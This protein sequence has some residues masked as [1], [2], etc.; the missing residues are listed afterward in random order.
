M[1]LRA[2]DPRVGHDPYDPADLHPSD[3]FRD[4]ELGRLA[5]PPVSGSA[6]SRPR[7]QP[8]RR[9]DF[10]G[11]RPVPT[12]AGRPCRHG[13]RDRRVRR[14]TPTRSRGRQER[15]RAVAG[16]GSGCDTGVPSDERKPCTPPPADPQDGQVTGSFPLSAAG[17][18]LRGSARRPFRPSPA[19]TVSTEVRVIAKTGSDPDRTQAQATGSE[20]RQGRFPAAAAASSFAHAGSRGPGS[21]SPSSS[22]TSRSVSQSGPGSTWSSGSRGSGLMPASRRRTESATVRRRG[23][24]ERGHRCPGPPANSALRGPSP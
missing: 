15:R 1:K 7:R 3:R 5:P 23:P 18:Q 2:A 8:S 6:R 12:R 9:A 14:R 24:R 16:D 21:G 17:G 19:R 13:V 22:A 20:P 4:A 10:H 11:P